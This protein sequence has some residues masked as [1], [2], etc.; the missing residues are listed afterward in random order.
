MGTGHLREGDAGL[1]QGVLEAARR[2]DP[3]PAVPWSLLDGLQRLVPCDRDVSFQRHDH[4]NSRRLLLQAVRADGSRDLRGPE[5]EEDDSFWGLWWSPM[6]SWP[7]RSGDLR[8]I[9]HTGDFF[10]SERARRADPMHAEVHPHITGELLVSMPAPPGEARRFVFMRSCG[11]PAVWP[12]RRSRHCPTHPPPL[13]TTG[14]RARLHT[15]RRS[16]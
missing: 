3:G 2:D 9:V 4:R 6:C 15:R 5:P 13:P 16:G 12:P 10:P 7:Q 1:L 11:T 14:A 8:S